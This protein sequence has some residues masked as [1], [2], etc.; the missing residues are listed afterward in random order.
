M[1]K[2]NVDNVVRRYYDY[3]APINPVY[4]ETINNLINAGLYTSAL[5]SSKAV[6]PETAGNILQYNN[7]KDTPKKAVALEVIVD[8]ITK[9]LLVGLRDG[10]TGSVDSAVNIDFKNTSKNTNL[11]NVDNI[12]SA[13]I[14]LANEIQLIRTTLASLIV[15]PAYTTALKT[16]NT[17]T[18]TSDDLTK[19]KL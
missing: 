10:L 4:S 5:E 15:E 14:T 19:H 7:G 3:K 8:S 16:I 2:A 17:P 6:D 18:I 9:G 11:D 13:I 1:T 12:H